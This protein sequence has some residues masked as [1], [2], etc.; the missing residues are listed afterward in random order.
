MCGL[1]AACWRIL[2]VLLV[3]FGAAT[4]GSQ[5]D[6]LKD[7][8]A[9]VRG[10]GLLK[11]EK[12]LGE[13]QQ[14]YPGSWERNVAINGLIWGMKLGIQALVVVGEAHS[15]QEMGTA[16]VNAAAAGGGGG[17]AEGGY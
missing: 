12:S 13:L 3:C 11:D 10:I 7:F 4:S 14:L 5:E 6:C 15:N 2:G 8:D 17:G 9:I 1:H 16:A